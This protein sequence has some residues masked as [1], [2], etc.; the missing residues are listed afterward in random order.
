MTY[1]NFICIFFCHFIYT[2][3]YLS[4]YKTNI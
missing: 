4:I 2:Y 1:I 3:T